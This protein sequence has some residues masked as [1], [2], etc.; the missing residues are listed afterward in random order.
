MDTSKFSPSPSRTYVIPLEINNFQ[1]LKFKK[2]VLPE[3]YENTCGT[4][5]W[6]FYNRLD[7]FSCGYSA[8]A[9]E[10]YQNISEA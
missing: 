1:N 10:D 2:F 9:F 5:T 3:Q 4:A 6:Y 7:G 8:F